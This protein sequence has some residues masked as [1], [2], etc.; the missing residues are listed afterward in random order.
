MLFRAY[1]VLL[2]PYIIYKQKIRND[3]KECWETRARKVF[4]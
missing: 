1:L 2:V 4:L 3:W